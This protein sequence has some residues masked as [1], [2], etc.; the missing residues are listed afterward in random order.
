MAFKGKPLV[1]KLKIAFS[2]SGYLA[3]AHAG[4]ACGMM[5]RGYTITEVAGTSGGSI[6]AAILAGG[7]TI[8]QIKKIVF[9]PLPKDIVDKSL[10]D[11]SKG[12]MHNQVYINQ[13]VVLENWLYS[14]LGSKTFAEAKIPV[15]IMATNL[16][17]AE[18]IEFSKTTTPNESLAFACRASSSVP[19]VYQPVVYNNK[20]LVDGGVRNNI[21]TNKLTMGDTRVGVR[22]V[23]GG[24]YDCT[25]IVGFSQQ[26]INCLLD[27]NEDNL[28]AWAQS[29]GANIAEVNCNPY[30]F[31]D[32]NITL[33]GKK[34]LFNRGRSAALKLNVRNGTNPIS[35]PIK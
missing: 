1:K 28:I 32:G 10:L 11:I 4:F 7:A 2:G 14:I 19:F 25:N 34:D 22:I 12:L 3:P 6:V 20:I 24:N 17:D 23:D 27:A 9:D 5:E 8:E 30:S 29:T 16:T 18:T 13:G 15:T 26:T 35:K 33:E 31:L 21:P